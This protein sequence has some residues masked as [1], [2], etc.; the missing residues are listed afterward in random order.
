VVPDAR[1]RVCVRELGR[2]TTRSKRSTR[3]RSDRLS[4]PHRQH[5]IP[6][7]IQTEIEKTYTWFYDNL[8]PDWKRQPV[9]SR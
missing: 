8:Y 4:G 6:A 5:A 9:A 2:S 1:R 7:R 3:A